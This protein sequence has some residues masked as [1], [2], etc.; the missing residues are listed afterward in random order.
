MENQNKPQMTQPADVQNPG[1]VWALE[2]YFS[3]QSP[4]KLQKIN[5]LVK[6]ATFIVPMI[7]RKAE[8]ES[9]EPRM[10]MTLRILQNKDGKAA[11]PVFTDLDQYKKRPA[12]EGER[13]V[14]FTMQQITEILKKGTLRDIVINPYDNRSLTMHMNIPQMNATSNAP[15]TVKP[16]DVKTSPLTEL[17][18]EACEKLSEML[19]K[20]TGV[21]RAWLTGIE[22][23]G[24]QGYLCVV[25]FENL[26]Q[27]PLFHAMAQAAGAALQGKKF[28]AAPYDS[29]GKKAVAEALPFYEKKMGATDGMV[30]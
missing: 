19:T 25:D 11:L 28:F 22:N 14:S 24:E 10:E 16:E 6:D 13:V 5:E 29:F 23:N 7:V 27:Q 2:S 20:V 30:M 15:A 17:P 18:A 1:L 12:A 26:N 21:R 4:E 3:A 9:A 8:E